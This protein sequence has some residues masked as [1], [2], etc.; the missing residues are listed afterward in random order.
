MILRRETKETVRSMGLDVPVKIT[1]TEETPEPE[2]EVDV[3]FK[4]RK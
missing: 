2:D 3:V 4:L 1:E